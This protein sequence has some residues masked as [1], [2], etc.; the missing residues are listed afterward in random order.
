MRARCR[1]AGLP[2][3]GLH[4]VQLR[5]RQAI[6]GGK[7]SWSTAPGAGDSKGA[8]PLNRLITYTAMASCMVP[9]EIYG[10][11]CYGPR[12]LN[13][14]EH[15]SSSAWE[16]P[17]LRDR[18]RLR[19]LLEDRSYEKLT[20]SGGNVY[21]LRGGQCSRGL[22]SRAEPKKVQAKLRIINSAAKGCL[23]TSLEFRVAPHLHLET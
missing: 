18:G 19:V 4:Y 11:G 2:L 17:Q 5:F 1:K 23:A 9:K 12:A 6:D 7:Q 13:R 22:G 16:R 14:G 15:A 3:E 20:D 10:R 8:L 21:W